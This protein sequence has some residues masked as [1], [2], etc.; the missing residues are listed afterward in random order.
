MNLRSVSMK[1]KESNN[2]RIVLEIVLIPICVL[3]LY[4][5]LLYNHPKISIV[6]LYITTLVTCIEF[7]VK[8][9]KELY[10]YKNKYNP[11]RL[12][13]VIFL[14]LL[15]ITLVINIFLKVKIVKLIITISLIILLVY[16]LVFATSN[17]IKIIK[18]KGRLLNTASGSF[19]SFIAFYIILM[20]LII[21]LK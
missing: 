7:I 17:I 18:N 21:Y 4:Y 2:L 14:F 13:F 16:L 5:T 10:T 8:Y 11:L 20:A 9:I 12:I 6:L 19:F 15:L 1:N 3:Y